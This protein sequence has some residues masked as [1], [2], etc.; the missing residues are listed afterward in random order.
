MEREDIVTAHAIKCMLLKDPTC[1]S[2]MSTADGLK[3]PMHMACY[4]R[5]LDLGVV[6]L[7]YNAYPEALIKTIPEHPLP[8][9]CALKKSIGTTINESVLRFIMNR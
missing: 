7:L 9:H 4:N 8:I 1:A 6:T 5:H 3:L 2:K